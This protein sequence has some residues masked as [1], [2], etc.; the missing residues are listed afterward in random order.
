[1]VS[2][3]QLR[4]PFV[5]GVVVERDL[6]AA[7][8]AAGA[9]FRTGADAVELNLA[10]LR[11]TT[12]LNRAF[13][14]Q[15][16]RP[17]YSSCRR[18]PFMA[19]YGAR[20][21]RLP[22][23]SDE[24][25]IG[26]QIALLAQGSAGLDFEADTF[27]P[28]RDEWTNDRAAIRKQRAVAAAAHR[29]G[30]A[31]IASWHPNRKLTLTEA[32][33]AARALRDRGADFI[34]IVER[35]HTRAEAVDS[36]AISLILHEKLGTPFVF[37]ALGAEAER[38]RPYMTAFGASYLLARPPVGANRLGAQPLVARARALIDLA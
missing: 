19:V 36:L 18:A 35:V 37:L 38:F 1:M 25:R 5:V 31:V 17:V 2:L 29:S 30:A 9:A 12:G 16:N 6:A 8:R 3:T 11:N 13:F 7:A 24:E 4:P 26:Q 33:R 10:S 32:L 20:F 15:W 22:A 21:S 34:K 14:S 23:R 27:A 28:N